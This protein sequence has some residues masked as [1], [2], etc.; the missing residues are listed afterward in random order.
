MQEVFELM[1]EKGGGF[2]NALAHA[3]FLADSDNRR[4]IEVSFDELIQRYTLQWFL[5][6]KKE[7]SENE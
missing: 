5:T 1:M 7:D 4:R 6:Q 3:W 2:A